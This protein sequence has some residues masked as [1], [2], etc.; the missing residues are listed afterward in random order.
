MATGDKQTVADAL[1]TRGDYFQDEL[2]NAF[3]S[4]PGDKQGLGVVARGNPT[5]DGDYVW[6]TFELQLPFFWC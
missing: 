6:A 2:G 5:C 1:E 3:R 4:S